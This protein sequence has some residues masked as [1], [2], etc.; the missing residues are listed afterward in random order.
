MLQRRLWRDYLENILWVFVLALVIRTFIFSSYR[1]PS[2]AME[3]AVLP[4]DFLIAFRLP[5]GLKLPLT[6]T[7]LVVA[8][9]TRGEVVITAFSEQ[10]QTLVLRRVVGVPGDRV[11]MRQGHL[12]INDE[13]CQYTVQADGS[14]W[15][16]GGG[17]S[18]MVIK[19]GREPSMTLPP[20]VVPPGFVFVLADQRATTDEAR[21]AGLVPVDLIEGRAELIWLSWAVGAKLRT[22]RLFKLIH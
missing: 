6:Q 21:K 13:I 19:S 22:E 1:M 16:T 14:E 2:A 11:E 10:P 15:E 8:A 20:V 17:L 12:Q 5:Y 7:K 4:G 18:H 9:P 3:P